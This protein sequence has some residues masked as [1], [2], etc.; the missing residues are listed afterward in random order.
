MCAW[1]FMEILSAMFMVK[2]EERFNFPYTYSVYGH[3]GK[4]GIKITCP[5]H[6]ATDP[7]TETNMS[8]PRTQTLLIEVHFNIILLFARRYA[9]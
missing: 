7:H 8:I 9:K 3:R 1:N 4:W 5:Q 6:P 2:H